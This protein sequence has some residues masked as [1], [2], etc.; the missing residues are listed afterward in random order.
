MSQAEMIG[1]VVIGLIA[2]FSVVSGV[3]II[4][5]PIFSLNKSISRLETSITVF[6]ESMN[7]YK[8]SLEKLEATNK[9]FYKKFKEL[10]DAIQDIK[11]N[12]QITHIR[13]SGSSKTSE[14]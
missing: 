11:V 1:V 5:R 10:E 12:C 7:L 9:E 4:L 6:G 8:I 2:L 14:T 3:I 13:K